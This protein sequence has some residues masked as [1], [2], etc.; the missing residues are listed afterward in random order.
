V[1][2][3]VLI[4]FKGDPAQL[5]TAINQMKTAHA[6][7]MAEIRSQ[8]L[9][10][11]RVQSQ[12]QKTTAQGELSV[13][14]QLAAAASLQRQRSAALI[15][16]WKQQERAAAQL[17]LGVKPVATNLQQITNIMQTLGSSIGVLQGP[18]NGISGR[19]TALGT[20]ARSTSGNLD[21]VAASATGAGGSIAAVAGPIGIAVLALAALA[22]GT[23]VA[24]KGLFDLAVAAADF[25]G[26]MFD[27]AQ[28]T[29]VAVEMLSTLEIIAATTGGS[30]ESITQSLVIFQGHLDEAQ[31]STSKAAIKFKELGISTSNTEDA[32]RDALAVLAKMPVGFHQT[33]EAAELFGRRGGKQIL[34]I[35]KEMDGDLVGTTAKLRA[36]G[37][38]ISEEDA[39][40]ADEFNDQ[41][42]LL[43]FQFRALLGKTVIPAA[44]EAL[45]AMSNLLSENQQLVRMLGDAF[46]FVS[47]QILAVFLDKVNDI[48][49]A[50]GALKIAAAALDDLRGIQQPLIQGATGGAGGNDRLAGLEGA[51]GAPERAART[52]RTRTGKSEAQ[53]ELESQLAFFKGLVAEASELTDQLDFL[54]GKLGALD[55][56]TREYAVTQAIANGALAKAAPGLREMALLTA[57]LSDENTKQIRLTKQLNDFRAQQD[58]AIKIVLQGEATYLEQADDLIIAIEKEGKLLSQSEIFWLRL[59]AAILQAAEAKERLMRAEITGPMVGGVEGEGEVQPE[60]EGDVAGPDMRPR[61]DQNISAILLLRAAIEEN[62]GG[63]A[64]S[65]ATAGLETMVEVFGQLGQAV[66][67]AVEAFVLYGNAGTSVRKVTAQILAGIA[68]QAAIKAIFHL[69]EGFAALAMAFFGIPNAGPSAA[70]HFKAA[71]IYGAIAGVA[72]ASGR[73]AAGSEFSK[74]N[75]GAAGSGGNKGTAAPAGKPKTVEADRRGGGD[76]ATG[77]GTFTLKLQVPDGWLGQEFRRDW[78]LNGATRLVV[79]TDGG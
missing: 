48:N 40:A 77:G 59:N 37:L 22:A 79:Q 26:K 68:Q 34:A 3:E 28:Q 27:M 15:A 71:A 56:T 10:T 62:L 5:L 54:E 74:A 38:V 12:T 35:L 60:F 7:A 50:L 30:I 42:A 75:E 76:S 2:N 41:L 31:D 70:A 20:L 44:L 67:Q 14:K 73:V 18:L 11:G 21:G 52:T 39:R 61:I 49:I 66:G 4:R 57:K 24:V 13:S 17:A 1:A 46:G 51:A 72:A 23:V 78:N 6:S 43:Q 63:T 8:T 36:M 58:A 9:Q 45:K 29:G 64:M 16:Q 69:A 19:F 25:R 32:F 55:T 47:N 53:R 33:N 65:A